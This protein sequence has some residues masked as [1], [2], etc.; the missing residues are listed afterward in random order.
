VRGAPR[1]VAGRNESSK[2]RSVGSAEDV[3]DGLHGG[4]KEVC[5]V[6]VVPPDKGKGALVCRGGLRELERN[7]TAETGKAGVD[8][9]R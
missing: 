2:R 6:L 4:G 5:M 3:T 8:V 7:R 1:E 9:R